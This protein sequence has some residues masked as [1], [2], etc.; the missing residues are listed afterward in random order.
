MVKVYSNGCPRCIVTKNLLDEK[1][2]EYELISDNETIV[3]VGREN[4][5]LSM[6]FIE[7]DNTFIADKKLHEW[8]HQQ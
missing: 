8:L 1:G 7:I 5:I 3:K 6:P 2:V 4:Q